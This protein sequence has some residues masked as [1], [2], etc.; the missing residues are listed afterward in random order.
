M[1]FGLSSALAIF[2]GYVKEFLAVKL[3]IFVIVYLDDI[4]IYTKDPSQPH[5]KVVCWVLDQ[6]W[7]Y[8]LFANLKKCCFHQDEVCFLEYVVSSKQISME[9]E[10]IEVVKKWSELK[11]VRDI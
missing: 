9:A 7:K 4:L 5:V 3:D 8:S 6:L 10:Q 1:L 2:Q 11:S